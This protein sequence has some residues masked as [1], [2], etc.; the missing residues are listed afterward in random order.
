MVRRNTMSAISSPFD[1]GSTSDEA[2]AFIQFIN[3][4]EP[5]VHELWCL[6]L[7]EMSCKVLPTARVEVTV[8]TVGEFV[9]N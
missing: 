3:G 2:T 6:V 4:Q 7:Y 1:S 9:T 8:G 5:Q